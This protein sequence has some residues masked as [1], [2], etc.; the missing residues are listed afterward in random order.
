MSEATTSFQLIIPE[1]SRLVTKPTKW[2]VRSAKTQISLGIRPVC[3]DS[4]QPGHPPS[5][6]RVFAVGMK[7]AWVLSYSQSISEYSDQ[8]GRMPRLIW[9]F[10]GR[11]CQYVDFVRRRLKYNPCI[12]STHAN[13]GDRTLPNAATL[14]SIVTDCA[15]DAYPQKE[16]Q[17][18]H[19]RSLVTK[20]QPLYFH[21]HD[22]A[23]LTFC[24]YFQKGSL[25]YIY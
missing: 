1:M 12:Y 3:E 25:N 9:V 10:A 24:L 2:H 5:L 20:V 21:W 7:K 8:T 4:D 15:N 13:R 23:S 14:P 6:I 18:A 17:T 11:T 16:V 22:S 19:L